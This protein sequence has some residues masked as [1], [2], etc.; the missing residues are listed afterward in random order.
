[1]TVAI[2][3]IRTLIPFTGGNWKS[4]V[5][6]EIFSAI[7]NTPPDF[8]GLENGKFC[9]FDM[10]KVSAEE[11]DN[12]AR[13]GGIKLKAKDLDKG[14][15]VTQRPLIVVYYQGEYYL[16][17]G[18]NRWIKFQDLGETTAPVWLYTLKEG[19]DFQE[20]KE[21]V[22]L[23]ANN[24]AKSDEATRRDFINTGV[25]W[26]ERNNLHEAVAN[27][28]RDGGIPRRPSCTLLEPLRPPLG[29]PNMQK[30]LK[31]TPRRPQDQPR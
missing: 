24:H 3:N 12:E 25:R 19:Y 31:T 10:T 13:A 20:V 26:A 6:N 4:V 11:E 15:D 28:F 5:E 9:I 14:W 30:I 18:F 27:H 23:S 17:D 16:W 8:W 29:P 21:H 2:S 7:V 1:M 22:Q